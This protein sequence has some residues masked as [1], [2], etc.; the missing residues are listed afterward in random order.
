MFSSLHHLFFIIKFWFRFLVIFF[1]FVVQI[2]DLLIN[3]IWIFF[4]CRFDSI[5]FTI[6]FRFDTFCY[7]RLFRFVSTAEIKFV[8]N[9]IEKRLDSSNWKWRSDCQHQMEQFEHFWMDFFDLFR[10]D[11]SMAY[12]YTLE[13]NLIDC[14]SSH[15]IVS[16]SSTTLFIT[17]KRRIVNEWTNEWIKTILILMFLTAYNLIE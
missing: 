9:R 8:A 14:Q 4:S 11:P 1:F 5:L 15:R 17:S 2:D 6:I 12:S 7:V 10:F 16:S 13:T 3:L